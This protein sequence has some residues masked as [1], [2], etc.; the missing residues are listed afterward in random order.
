MTNICL[1]WSFF[2]PSQL[3]AVHCVGWVIHDQVRSQDNV[4]KATVLVWLLV[5]LYLLT[6]TPASSNLQVPAITFLPQFSA[7]SKQKLPPYKGY[8]TIQEMLEHTSR[9]Q[10]RAFTVYGLW[11]STMEEG[12]VL[13]LWMLGATAIPGHY[14][15]FQGS[16]PGQLS[17]VEPPNGKG[18]MSGSKN[19]LYRVFGFK[20]GGSWKDITVCFI[21]ILVWI[22]KEKTC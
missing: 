18:T 5:S 22:F 1:Q 14:Q 12:L 10:A 6:K 9:L 17:M 16:F 19:R 13:S 11:H 15:N 21:N 20:F 7:I 2:F 8:F 4:T 3:A